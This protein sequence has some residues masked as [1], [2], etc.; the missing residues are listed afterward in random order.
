MRSLLHVVGNQSPAGQQLPEILPLLTAEGVVFRRAQLHMIAA[1]PGGGKTMLALWYAVKSGVPTLYFSADSD[2]RTMTV[3]T[4]AIL[5]GKTVREIENLLN[6]DHAYIVEKAL[7]EGASHIRFDFDPGP[8][9]SDIEEEIHAYVEL[10][11]DTPHMIVLD[12]LLNVAGSNDNEWTA[13]RDAMSAFH[14]MARET[15]S[16]F[17]VLH[18]VSENDSKPNVP[19]PRKSLQGK[20]SQL[21]ELVLSVAL[22]GTREQYKIATVKNRHG[23][24][25]PTAENFITVSVDPARM[26]LYNGS[27]E[28]AKA[29]HRREVTGS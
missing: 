6:S 2:A 23:Q 4:A 15:E 28:K 20:V 14:Y 10:H 18:H 19:A 22:D 21:P 8:S 29:D 26:T 12:N 9:L 11:A 24:A 25:D 13:M 27:V 7:D 1:Q 5:M 3:R 16:A 17:V